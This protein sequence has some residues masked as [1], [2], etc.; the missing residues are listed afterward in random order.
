M[1]QGDDSRGHRL[2]DSV[3]PIFPQLFPTQRGGSHLRPADLRMPVNVSPD[4]DDFIDTGFHTGLNRAHVHQTPF[5]LWPTGHVK[6]PKRRAVYQNWLRPSRPGISDFSCWESRGTNPAICSGL[7][8][9]KRG[10][11]VKHPQ[12]SL[13]TNLHRCLYPG[14]LLFQSSGL[15]SKQLI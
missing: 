14:R 4:R 10:A 6:R 15:L 5:L 12:K 8:Q 1:D 13:F 2:L 3:H 11:F 7:K 9:I